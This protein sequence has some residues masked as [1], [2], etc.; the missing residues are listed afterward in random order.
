MTQTEL[1]R[2]KILVLKGLSP[3]DLAAELHMSEYL[4]LRLI[5]NLGLKR[6]DIEDECDDRNS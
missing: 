1:N 6:R 2:F 4:V 5:R 3:E